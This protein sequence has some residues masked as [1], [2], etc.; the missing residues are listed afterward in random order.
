VASAV[1][2]R[3]DDKPAA[4]R[5]LLPDVEEI[6]STLRPSETGPNLSAASP[7]TGGGFA[8]AAAAFRSGFLLVLTVAILGAA[9]YSHRL[10]WPA[11]CPRWPVR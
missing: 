8:K 1:L 6:N 4:R 5:D 9:I 7:T 3:G 2:N 10:R 11:G